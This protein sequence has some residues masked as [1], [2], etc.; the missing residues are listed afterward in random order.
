M[1]NSVETGSVSFGRYLK[2]IREKQGISLE[3]V[4]DAICV[5][6]RQ[7]RWIEAEDHQR[8]PG[9]VYV[10]GILRAYALEVGVDPDDIAERY[11]LHRLAYDDSLKRES[12]ILAAGKKAFPRS[13]LALAVLGLV[14]ALSLYAYTA[15]ENRVPADTGSDLHEPSRLA[16]DN[17]EREK[18]VFQRQAQEKLKDSH[19]SY[20]P[21]D[22]GLQMLSIDALSEVTLNIQID[23]QPYKKYRLDPNDHMELAARDGFHVLISDAAGVRLSL[24]GKPVELYSEPGRSIDISLPERNELRQHGH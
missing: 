12:Q 16:A 5:S 20:A 23:D 7:L 15:L 13:L 10:K 9:E 4:A 24:N 8:L 21:A 17:Q 3:T 14:M 6:V 18:G 1:A 19:R 11:R 2:I 22:A